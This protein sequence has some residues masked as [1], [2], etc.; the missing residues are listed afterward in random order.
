MTRRQ[1]AVHALGVTIVFAGLLVAMVV[2]VRLGG[3]LS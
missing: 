2:L 3:G 1:R